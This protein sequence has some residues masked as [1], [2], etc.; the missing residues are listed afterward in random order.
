MITT[1]KELAES[2]TELLDTPVCEELVAQ[3]SQKQFNYISVLMYKAGSEGII[4]QILDSK[5]KPLYY[6]D[7][8]SKYLK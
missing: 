2:L 6:R 3:L 1:T 5:K 8:K 4:K 7:V